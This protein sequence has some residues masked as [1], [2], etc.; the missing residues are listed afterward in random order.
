MPKKV[1]AAE[2]GWDR[3]GEMIGKK[4]E[5]GMKGKDWEMWKSCAP[6]HKDYSGGFFGR[7]LFIIGLLVALNSLGL[8]KEVNIWIQVLMGV[9][10]ALMRLD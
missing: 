8:L 1:K 5:K 6:Y 3:I 10:F 4:I 2:P 7:T 9:G